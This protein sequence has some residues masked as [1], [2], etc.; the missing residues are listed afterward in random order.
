[1]HFFRK[2][3]LN[4]KISQILTTLHL[5]QSLKSILPNP[6]YQIF[7]FFRPNFSNL[8]HA[9]QLTHHQDLA[10]IAPKSPS[11]RA[12][13]RSN[14][15]LPPFGPLHP[16]LATMGFFV[17]LITQF[18]CSPNKSIC[19]QPDQVPSKYMTQMTYVTSVF[20]DQFGWSNQV[21]LVNLVRLVWFS[22]MIYVLIL[23]RFFE[24]Y[25][26]IYIYIYIHV[27]LI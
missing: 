16:N 23:L 21:N 11:T 10:V 8:M 27:Y 19:L 1:M 3:I 22:L 17:R 7:N 18:H 5:L 6:L 13:P 20:Q 14:R 12:P 24:I 15:C 9:L 26:D 2:N 4:H 25:Y